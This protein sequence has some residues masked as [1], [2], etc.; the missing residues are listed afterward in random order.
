MHLRDATAR[1]KEYGSINQTVF[2]VETFNDSDSKPVSGDS[3]PFP[4]REPWD[5]VADS[6]KGVLEPMKGSNSKGYLEE[7][8]IQLVEVGKKGEKIYRIVK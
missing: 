2:N 5:G 6:E 3:A 8:K 4:A 1:Q 7:D